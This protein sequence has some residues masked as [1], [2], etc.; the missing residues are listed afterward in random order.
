[1]AMYRKRRSSEEWREEEERRSEKS[2]VRGLRYTLGSFTLSFLALVAF[3]VVHWDRPMGPL[4]WVVG[5]LAL[6]TGL[7]ILSSRNKG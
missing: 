5:G 6:G 3:K 7:M 2:R 1:M 4:F